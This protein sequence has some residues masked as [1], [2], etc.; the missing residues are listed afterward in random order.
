MLR[1]K[2]LAKISSKQLSK[3]DSLIVMHHILMRE[4]GW[5]PL[6]EF[7]KLPMQ[8]IFDLLKMIEKEAKE[9]NGTGRRPKSLR[10]N[11]HS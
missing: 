10:G 8:T 2:I 4:Y 11:K 5:I 1:D 6:E 9:A 7:K 3:I